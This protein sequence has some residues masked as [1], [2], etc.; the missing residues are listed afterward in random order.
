MQNIE[1]CFSAR[2][3]PLTPV[4]ELTITPVGS[5]A[6]AS[7]NGASARVAAVTWHPGVAIERRFLQVL[8]MEFGQAEHRGCQQLGLVVR[9]A[10]PRRVERGVLQPKCGRQVDQAADVAVQL[11]RQRHRRL[12][13]QP[14]EHDVEPLGL[15]RIELVEHQVRIV[16]GEARVQHAGQACRLGCR[17]WRRPRR[18]QDVARTAA[19]V[20]LPCI[21]MRR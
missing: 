10:V 13:R 19:A 3:A 20:L 14:E 4:I 1:V 12:V 11:R 6:P 17:R 8:A 16:R 21:R 9:E 5:I 18:T 2:P 7:T 15:R